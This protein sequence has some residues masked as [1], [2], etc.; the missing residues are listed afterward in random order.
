MSSKNAPGTNNGV[1]GCA[2]AV[3]QILQAIGLAPLGVNPLNVASV[4]AALQ[5]GRGVQITQA[6]TMPGDLDIQN[7][8]GHIGIC[9][10]AGCT[11]VYSNSSS[12]AAFVWVS[13]PSFPPSYPNLPSRFY[14]VLK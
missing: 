1:E 12:N 9:M 14:R 6:N 13:G 7:Q 5:A 4:E 11:T 2:W 8:D 3:N 10:N